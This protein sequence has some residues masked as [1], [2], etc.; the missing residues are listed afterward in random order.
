MV[1]WTVPFALV[2]LPIGVVGG[3]V[4]VLNHGVRGFR[5]QG[6]MG[7]AW[8]P[9]VD[10]VTGKLHRVILTPRDHT[11]RESLTKYLYQAVEERKR[12][13]GSFLPLLL[14]RNRN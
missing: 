7:G 3:T 4:F 13:E 10:S 9:R 8:F 5:P 6:T 14:V 1:G 11:R 12:N 2:L